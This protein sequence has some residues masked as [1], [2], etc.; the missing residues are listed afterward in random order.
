[1]DPVNNPPKSCIRAGLL[2]PEIGFR[3][4]RSKQNCKST[5]DVG[6]VVNWVECMRFLD[7]VQTQ[8]PYVHTSVFSCMVRD[9]GEA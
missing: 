3:V 7:T 1:M 2:I 6:Y 8:L 4:S 5:I 9:Q